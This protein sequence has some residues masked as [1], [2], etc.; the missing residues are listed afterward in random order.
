M[1][2]LYLTVLFGA[3]MTVAANAQL[4]FVGN[5][6]GEVWDPQNPREIQAEADGSYKVMINDLSK[7]KMSTVKG[8][9]DT[10]NSGAFGYSG[11][12]SGP[13]TYQ[14]VAWGDDQTMPWAGDWTIEINADR[15]EMTLSTTTP[16][17][18]AVDFY[19][20]GSMNG[21][22]TPAAWKFVQVEGDVYE[23]RNV[24][25]SATD[26]FKV[27]D[28]SWGRIN[29]GGAT[30]ME[31]DKEYTLSYNSNVNCTMGADFTGVVQFDLSSHVIKMVSGEIEPPKPVVK[32]LYIVGAEYGNWAD[33]A[34]EYHFTKEENVYT[35]KLN[36]LSGEWKI[37]NGTWEYSFGAGGDP[38]VAGDNEVWFNSSVNFTYNTDN[39]VVLT[40]TVP[41]GGDVIDSGVPAVLN[42]TEEV[43]GIEGID[44]ET[45][46][47]EYYTLQGVKVANPANGI[48]LERRGGKVSKV[49]R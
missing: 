36:G 6:Q 19:L 37:W 5:F 9:W 24:Q 47:A 29:Y 30:K 4:Y 25:L 13:G 1:K 12:I 20:R 15:T 46:A 45:G 42:I 18:D 41:D 40:L 22:G 3:L 23:V 14:L 38:L 16:K 43:N 10:F 21:W 49:V 7:F 2:K 35:L 32:E 31:A 34:E 33:T 44:A 26:E 17:P 11:E 27:A 39:R 8:D 28:A 48:F